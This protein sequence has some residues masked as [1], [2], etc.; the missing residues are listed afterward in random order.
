MT[1]N[2]SLFKNYYSQNLNCHNIHIVEIENL[3][4]SKSLMNDEKLRIM[5]WFI[6]QS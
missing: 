1:I 5:F 3:Q 2:Q 6:R 4:I